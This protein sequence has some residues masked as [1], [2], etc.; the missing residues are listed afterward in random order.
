MG[1]DFIIIKNCPNLI[2]HF[3]HHCKKNCLRGVCVCHMEGYSG[4]L[5]LSNKNLSSELLFWA[6]YAPPICFIHHHRMIP[7]VFHTRKKTLWDSPVNEKCAR[8]SV[9]REL[10]FEK[11]TVV[12]SRHFRFGN[13]FHF[14]LFSWDTDLFL[15]WQIVLPSPI[16]LP[17]LFGGRNKHEHFSPLNPILFFLRKML[18]ANPT[19]PPPQY[20]VGE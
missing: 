3:F 7:H 17:P 11:L 1:E 13:K 20:S 18:F 16:V 19:F 14:I 9:L 12:F 8:N 6:I 5:P 15:L 2:R 10:L 4:Y